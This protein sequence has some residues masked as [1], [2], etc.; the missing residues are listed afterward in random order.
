MRRWG[1]KYALKGLKPPSDEEMLRLTEIANNILNKY[2]KYSFYMK[3]NKK[4][5]I[6]C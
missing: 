1:K 4:E 5:G 2:G 6:K 3:D